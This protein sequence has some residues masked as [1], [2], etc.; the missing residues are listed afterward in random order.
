MPIA[1]S[2]METEVVEKQIEIIADLV[3]LV[4]AWQKGPLF[5]A[6][7]IVFHED[8]PALKKAREYLVYCH[9][10]GTCP[11]CRGPR[12]KDGRCAAYAHVGAAPGEALGGI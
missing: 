2:G 7:G 10:F 4:G 11:I 8:P 5:R 3:D 1:V 9:A 6:A 12:N